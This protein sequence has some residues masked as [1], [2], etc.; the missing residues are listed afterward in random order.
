MTLPNI[1]QALP[2]SLRLSLSLS[3][4]DAPRGLSDDDT[5]FMLLDGVRHLGSLSR[6]AHAIG[7]SYRYAW[8]LLR[9]KEAQL[10]T[11]LLIRTRGRGAILSET[12][13]RLIWA[14]KRVAS[15]FAAVAANLE[16]EFR[17]QIE[18]GSDTDARPGL[19]LRGSPDDALAALRDAL[20]R[21][22]DA[23]PVDLRF[24]DWADNLRGLARGECDLASLACARGQHRGTVQHLGARRWLDR[25]T[26]RL[27]RVGVR[28]QVL[29]LR[30]GLEG[31]VGALADLAGSG[32]RYVQRS[33]GT[34]ARLLADQ[35][36]RDARVALDGDGGDEPGDAGVAARIAGGLA[37]C[38]I[39]RAAAARQA[40]LSFVPLAV[41][42]CYLLV[43][44]ESLQSPAI[45]ALIDVLRDARIRRQLAYA[46]GYDMSA[47]GEVLAL[48]A[49]LPWM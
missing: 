18:A 44:E 7:M 32:L 26:Q 41:E 30:P 49:A 22:P 10:K 20:A 2:V 24:G 12:G 37:D 33:A 15:H 29:M 23:P 43:R 19:R 31:R 14:H 17:G 39:G 5:L 34:Y 25:R 45:G 47:A 1:S 35:L 36:L 21:L 9:D 40:G 3:G 42:D 27:I 48:D 16:S 11:T 4:A 8:G 28:G 13:A 46:E 6:A 38:G